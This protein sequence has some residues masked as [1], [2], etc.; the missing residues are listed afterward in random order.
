VKSNLSFLLYYGFVID[1]NR[2]NTVTIGLKPSTKI[3]YA[4]YKE[5]MLETLH[6]LDKDDYVFKEV[7][8]NDAVDSARLL[9]YMRIMI[10]DESLSDLQNYYRRV[11]AIPQSDKNWFLP[12]ITVWNEKILLKDLIALAENSLEKYSETYEEDVKILEEQDKLTFNQRNCVVY[13]MGEKKVICVSNSR[14]IRI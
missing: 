2:N 11:K 10:Y 4:E 13:R 14:Y 5:Q 6:G 3:K 12:S 7:Y 9:E 1:N 8:D